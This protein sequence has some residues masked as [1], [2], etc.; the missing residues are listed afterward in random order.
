MSYIY[1]GPYVECPAREYPV[2]SKV[3]GCVNNLCAR[4]GEKR[5]YYETSGEDFCGKCG[6][7]YG[8]I[9]IKETRRVSHYE[10][11]G[12]NE[13]LACLNGEEYRA[14][15]LYFGSNVKWGDRPCSFDINEDFH[16]DLLEVN[17]A[18][19]IEEFMRVFEAEIELLNKA[20]GSFKMS[21]GVH[22]WRL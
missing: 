14:P 2:D 22:L 5:G 11:L 19:E 18:A 15:V 20:Y 16:A 4:H 8:M 17:R 1:I 21:W 3:K 13:R 7:K 9:P 6:S 10:A 12:H